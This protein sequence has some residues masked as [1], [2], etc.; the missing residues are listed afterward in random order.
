V[1]RHGSKKRGP[2]RPA[3]RRSTGG[4]GRPSSAGASAA[5]AARTQQRSPTFKLVA[6]IISGVLALGLFVGIELWLHRTT[7]EEAALLAAAGAAAQTAGCDQVA[8]MAPYAGDLDRAHI[9]GSDVP[10]PPALSSYPSIPP[11]S[12]PHEPAPLGAGAYHDPPDVWAAIH[13]L[14]HA[15]VIVW[16]DPALASTP[17]V[18][19]LR[20][21]FSRNDEINHVIVAPYSY[22]AQGAAGRLPAGTGMA[23]AAWHHLQTC[24]RPSLEVAYAFVHAFR[25][26]LYQWGS[27]KGDAPERFSPI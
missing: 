18:E 4:A 27:Y 7:P 20:A 17:E 8:R 11:V 6:G 9:G 5:P 15:G 12:G 26:N 10:T 21:F 14:E 16:I 22:P 1:A 19:R 13:S 23:L 24:E 3:P 25:F 2:S